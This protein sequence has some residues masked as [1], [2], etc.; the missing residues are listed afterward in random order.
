MPIVGL[1][2]RSAAF[3]LIGVLRKGAPRQEGKNRPGEDLTHFRF[4]S[5]DPAALEA[6]HAAYGDA[7]TEL[8]VM[9]PYAT[10]Q[11]NWQAWREE[12]VAGGLVHRCDGVFSVIW[13]DDTGDYHT[14]RKPC[15]YRD[16]DDERQRGCKPVGRLTVI[17]PRLQ[18][19]AYVTVLTTSIHDIMT[20]EENLAAAAMIHGSLLGIPFVLRRRPRMISTPGPN[21]TRVRREKWLLSL[22]PD[23][24]W[25]A[26]KLA[27]LW[28]RALP[29]GT[30]M[31]LPELQAPADEP[32]DA[33]DDVPATPIERIVDTTTGEVV[34]R[35]RPARAAPAATPPKP[36]AAPS[37]KPPT[38]S[39]GANGVAKSGPGR[40][41]EVHYCKQC[42]KVIQ[43]QTVNGQTYSSHQLAQYTL[44]NCG[45]ELCPACAKPIKEA[46]LPKDSSLWGQANRV[47]Q[48]A[49]ELDVSLPKLW[50]WSTQ[51]DVE[52]WIDEGVKLIEEARQFAEQTAPAE[53][54]TGGQLF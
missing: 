47:A 34:E 13:R 49:Q 29:P 20:L 31:A 1:S 35:P 30:T 52:K 40:A 28:Q 15:P 11:E 19:L 36:S 48:D 37:A 54:A 10:P 6:F 43:P 53:T 50:Q 38:K 24:R 22:E 16:V 27:E 4:T 32:D 7:P 9:L 41:A 12:W 26:A 23:P 51:A 33:D 17:L 39:N 8:V 21:G 3:P 18:R 25:V 2:E 5:D 44:A 46:A 45:I 42:G 14:G